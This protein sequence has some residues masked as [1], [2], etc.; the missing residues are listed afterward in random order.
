MSA[1]SQC[2]LEDAIKSPF[3]KLILLCRAPLYW[4]RVPS[5]VSGLAHRSAGNAPKGAGFR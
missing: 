3:G 1:I 2:S 5:F 4:L